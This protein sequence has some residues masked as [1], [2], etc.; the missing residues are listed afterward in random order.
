MAKVTGPLFSISAS[1]KLADSMVHFGWKGLHV[2]RQWVKPAN[3]QSEGQGDRREMLGGLG[4][5]PK[6]VQDDTVYYNHAKS[7]EPAGQTWLSY[8]VKYIMETYF[9]N[10]A[11]YTA[12]W[13]E[14]QAHPAQADF[15]T[16]A[17]ALGL[18]T[19]Q[20]AYKS[21]SSHF[22]PGFQLYCLMVFGC[23]QYLLDN[24]KFET[25]PYTKAKATWVDADIVL[26]VADFSA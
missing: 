17:E 26:M 19:F 20:L 15:T 9:A 18:A 8:F 21:H 2:V 3:P 4:R 10:L 6:Y 7:V 16:R 24:T 12:L 23:D 11:G 25:A 14:W 5:A 13:D 1:G 22:Y